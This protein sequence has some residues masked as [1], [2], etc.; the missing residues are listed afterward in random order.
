MKIGQSAAKLPDQRCES[1]S[2][3]TFN[4]YRKAARAE[5][6]RVG[7]SGA[8]RAA[9]I[10]HRRS[11]SPSNW[12]DD[13]VSTSGESPELQVKLRAELNELC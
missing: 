8:A 9:G 5:P 12:K 2:G 11:G 4:D 10:A 7:P 1:P 3:R 6:S 13:I